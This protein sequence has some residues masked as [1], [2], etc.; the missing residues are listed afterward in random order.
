M[1]TSFKSIFP[2]LVCVAEQRT[3]R[4]AL[5]PEDSQQGWSCCQRDRS[6]SVSCVYLETALSVT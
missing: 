3:D 6:H 2:S 1:Y 5:S 4:L